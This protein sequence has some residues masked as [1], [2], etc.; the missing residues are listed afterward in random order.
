MQRT[1]SPPSFLEL[2]VPVPQPQCEA[3][4]FRK[5]QQIISRGHHSTGGPQQNVPGSLA[6]ADGRESEMQRWK[7]LSKPLSPSAQRGQAGVFLRPLSGPWSWNQ[8][9]PK[10]TWTPVSFLPLQER[11]GQGKAAILIPAPTLRLNEPQKSTYEPT[12]Y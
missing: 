12:V 3:R 10:R 11:T 8:T 4:P 6:N 9:A 2:P 7:A 5:L 1:G